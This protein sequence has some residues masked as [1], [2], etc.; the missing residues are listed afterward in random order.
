MSLLKQRLFSIAPGEILTIL[1]KPTYSLKEE[2]PDIRLKVRKFYRFVG[3]FH[4]L[5]LLFMT[6]VVI[7]PISRKSFHAC[8]YQMTWRNVVRFLFSIYESKA[9]LRNICPKRLQVLHQLPITDNQIDVQTPKTSY[10]TT[11][12]S[13]FGRPFLQ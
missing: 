4:A 12:T 9:F 10:Y 3:K 13:Q 8:Y 11:N 6:S 7:N 2:T 5:F 1:S